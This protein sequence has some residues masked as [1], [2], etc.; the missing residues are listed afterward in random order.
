MNFDEK[1]FSFSCDKDISQVFAWASGSFANIARKRKKNGGRER[2]EKKRE[3]EKEREKE[4]RREGERKR[5]KE[6]K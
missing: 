3:R 4:R 6:K 1:S 2:R 5:E